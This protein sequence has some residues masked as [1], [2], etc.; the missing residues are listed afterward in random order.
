MSITIFFSKKKIFLYSI[1]CSL[2]IGCSASLYALG[3]QA[4]IKASESNRPIRILTLDSGGIRGIISAYSLMYL[5]KKSGK[6]ISELFDLIVGV[7]TGAVQAAMLTIP[8]AKHQPRYSAEQVLAYYEHDAPA[9]LQP[10]LWWRVRSLGGLIKPKTNTSQIYQGIQQETQNLKLSDLL[11]HVI[12]LTYDLNNARFVKLDNLEAAADPSKNFRL[13]DAVYSAISAP[14]AIAPREITN[15]PDTKKYL[16][17]DGGLANTNPAASALLIAS[18]LYPDRPK[19]LLSLGNGQKIPQLNDA[20]LKNWGLLQWSRPLID[21]LFNTRNNTTHILLAIFYQ[22]HLMHLD[23]YLPV[24][25]VLKPDIQHSFEGSSNEI[26]QLKAI[27]QSTVEH[28]QQQLDFF[29]LSIPEMIKQVC[30]STNSVDKAV[31]QPVEKFVAPAI[32]DL[33]LEP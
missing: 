11:S 20:D 23:H 22:Q 3:D 25:P 4:C 12:I 14:I 30:L 16:L 2:F 33:I 19:Y 9:M 1:F 8:N 21:I 24:V 10:S 17:V 27:G 5:E 18:R 28:Y 6:P 31:G 7:S 29:T 32:D 26:G 13:T 15:L